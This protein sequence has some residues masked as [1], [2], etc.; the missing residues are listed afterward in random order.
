MIYTT[1]FR[2]DDAELRDWEAYL[3]WIEQQLAIIATEEVKSAPDIARR[4]SRSQQCMGN[5]N[6]GTARPYKR[7]DRK[8]SIKKQP[9]LGPVHGSKIT[10]RLGNRKPRTQTRDSKIVKSLRGEHEH[11]PGHIPV[12]VAPKGS[13]R[14]AE[15]TVPNSVFGVPQ[16]RVSKRGSCQ[17]HSAD[18]GGKSGAGKGRKKVR[19]AIAEFRPRRSLRIAEITT[20]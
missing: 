13:F 12:W 5:R 9:M 2:S 8:C 20:R 11:S 10:K 15:P 17:I 19:A 14:R 18:G 6:S 4:R 3:T 16:S 1:R 7:P